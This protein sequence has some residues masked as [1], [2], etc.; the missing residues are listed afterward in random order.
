MMQAPWNIDKN[1][2]TIPDWK[3]V[4]LNVPQKSVYHVRQLLVTFQLEDRFPDHDNAFKI[5]G[6]GPGDS[7][8]TR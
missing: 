2:F 3:Y 7:P 5:H 1:T 8:E 4:A 6:V